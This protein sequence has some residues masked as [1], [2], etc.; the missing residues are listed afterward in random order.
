MT[1]RRFLPNVMRL[2]FALYLGSGSADAGLAAHLSLAL[3]SESLVAGSMNFATSC[4]PMLVHLRP[5]S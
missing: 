5:L 1:K 4:V 3:V 2:H